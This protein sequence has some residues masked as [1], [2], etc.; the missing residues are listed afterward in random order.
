MCKIANTVL[1]EN[2]VRVQTLN[3]NTCYKAVV[4]K[5]GWYWWKK[6]KQMDQWYRIESLET[7]PHKYS[8]LTFDK[9]A[10]EIQ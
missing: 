5:T 6:N 4:T 3:I 2:K 8:Q 1:K 9:G 10:K 7:E